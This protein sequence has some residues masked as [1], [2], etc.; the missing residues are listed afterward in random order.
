[1]A[2]LTEEERRQLREAAERPVEQPPQDEDERFVAPSP[3]ARLR[4]IR[5]ATQAARFH[6]PA[7]FRPMR[8]N[9]WK[10]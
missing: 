8:G 9:N 5:F 6:R 10:L 2:R 3:E 1:M 7:P 4:Y